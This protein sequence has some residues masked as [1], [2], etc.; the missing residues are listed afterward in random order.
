VLGDLAGGDR[1]EDL[2]EEW[3]RLEK[4]L[5]LDVDRDIVELGEK[6]RKRVD[7]R[8]RDRIRVHF[9]VTPIGTQFALEDEEDQATKSEALVVRAADGTGNVIP[10]PTPR[11]RETLS[12]GRITMNLQTMISS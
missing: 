3:Q 2:A 4:E 7:H 1:R 5:D 8:G 12:L 6:D 9:I 11:L 10:R